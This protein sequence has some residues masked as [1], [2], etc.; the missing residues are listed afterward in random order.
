MFRTSSYD[1]PGLILRYMSI[2][3]LCEVRFGLEDDKL[4]LPLIDKSIFPVVALHEALCA[5]GYDDERAQISLSLHMLSKGPSAG[6]D[7]FRAQLEKAVTGLTKNKEYK[8][9]ADGGTS[10][11]SG[12]DG[13]AIEFKARLLQ[14]ALDLPAIA[15]NEVLLHDTLERIMSADIEPSWEHN[16]ELAVKFERQ[17]STFRIVIPSV[18][19]FLFNVMRENGESKKY[20]L[21]FATLEKIVV[22]TL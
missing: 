11:G 21:V 10:V 22:D 6:E 1:Q 20:E 15:K 13:T 4:A 16:V 8:V 17:G 2:Y 14:L 18:H 19:W 7:Y 3:S 5:N 12:G 9:L